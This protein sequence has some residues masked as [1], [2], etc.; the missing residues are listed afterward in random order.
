LAFFRYQ[1]IISCPIIPW[2]Y[3]TLLVAEGGVGRWGHFIW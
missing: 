2:Q 3:L 1:L